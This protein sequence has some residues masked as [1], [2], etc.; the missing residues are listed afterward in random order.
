MKYWEIFLWGHWS[1]LPWIT[2]VTGFPSSVPSHTLM[3]KRTQFSLSWWRARKGPG[4][5]VTAGW[6]LW[7]KI[8]LTPLMQLYLLGLHFQHP[9]EHLGSQI[10][11]ELCTDWVTRWISGKLSY[12]FLS[13]NARDPGQTDSA[14]YTQ[15]TV[16]HCK[17]ALPK[18]GHVKN[19]PW[20]NKKDPVVRFI[21][22]PLNTL[23]SLLYR[24]F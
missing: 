24:A 8:L 23:P 15:V 2:S 10:A 7:V 18:E 1:P 12:I 3:P 11:W 19:V 14:R 13:S 9:E 5:G 21:W 22:D 6:G 20:K 4:A 17:S 16:H